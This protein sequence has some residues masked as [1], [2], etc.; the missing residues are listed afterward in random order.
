MRRRSLIAR[1]VLRVRDLQPEGVA[2][3]QQNAARLHQRLPHGAVGRL[4]EV[5]ALGVLQVRLSRQQAVMRN[6]RQRRPGQHAPVR[7]SARVRQHEALPVEIEG[8]PAG[9]RSQRSARAPAP[10]ARAA[11]APPHSASAAHSGPRPPRARRWSPCIGR[12]RRR[13]GRPSRSA[14]NSSA[15]RSSVCTA[16]ISCTCSSRSCSSQTKRSSGSSSSSCFSPRHRGLVVLCPRA[17]GAVGE[18]RL[19]HGRRGVRL[20]A[21]PLPGEGRRETGQ[22][23]D[24]ARLCP[25]ALFKARAGVN[26]DAGDLLLVLRPVL[27]RVSAGRPAR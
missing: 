7:F 21:E 10:A 20:R 16:P 14:R 5:A 6:I 19:Q 8:S 4:R 17:A 12:A 18:R 9:S 27:R 26:A 13:S 1:P 23:A 24:V 2:G 15:H 3:L 25:L 22:R 11:G